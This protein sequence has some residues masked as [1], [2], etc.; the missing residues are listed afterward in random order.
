[1]E[2]DDKNFGAL[3]PVGWPHSEQNLAVGEIRLPQFAQR[4]SRAEA[5]SSQNFAPAPFSCWQLG[6]IIQG[7]KNRANAGDGSVRSNRQQVCI[8]VWG[9]PG[10]S[11]NGSPGGFEAFGDLPPARSGAFPGPGLKNAMSIMDSE[12]TAARQYQTI[13]R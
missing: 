1:M 6:Q 4:G 11:G 9:C 8:S 13:N 5:H 7:P 10:I 12:D 3:S 2:R